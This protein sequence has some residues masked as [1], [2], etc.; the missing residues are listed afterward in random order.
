[1]TS[2]QPKP[3]GSN[4]GAT[5][6]Y[7][8]RWTTDSTGRSI[9]YP[10]GRS[11]GGY[12]VADVER[13]QR[14]READKHF[15]GQS[16]T[17]APFA[18]FLALPAFYFLLG[19]HPIMGLA[20]L[21]A[22]IVLA[23]TVEWLV[24]R[25]VMAT[26]LSACLVLALV[27]VL[28]LVVYLYDQRLAAATATSKTTD[29]YS[30]ISR[31]LVLGAFSALMLLGCIV[32]WNQIS[33]KAGPNRAMLAVFAFAT[34]TLIFA[35][36]AGANFYDP[37][38]KI[39]LAR[40]TFYCGWRVK[41]TD[42]SNIDKRWGGR[43]KEN[44]HIQFA[45]GRSP[46][47]DERSS[48]SCEI[49]GLTVDDSEVYATVYKQWQTAKSDT[50]RS[51]S[52]TRALRGQLEQIPV[53]SSRE[54][55]TAVLGEPIVTRPGYPGQVSF[56]SETQTD[57]PSGLTPDLRVVA[58]YFDENGRVNRLAVYRLENGKVIDDISHDTLTTASAYYTLLRMVL[59]R[60]ARTATETKG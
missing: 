41:W 11:F 35:G 27:G 33:A 39:V 34:L 18:G 42:I 15:E 54:T 20:L 30:D 1:M 23:A 50:T 49:D 8:K 44:L 38:P 5:Q 52:S 10:R 48:G 40:D 32:R 4:A 43:F 7:S 12:V 21:L 55:A 53:G 31:Y 2:D 57:E 59:L 25:P 19:S 47:R 17:I 60:P 22:L 6:E 26:L 16:K 3:P 58:V 46:F 29:F 37:E 45:P 51:A 24:R 13:E 56:Y 14:I 28:S 36:L 9:Y